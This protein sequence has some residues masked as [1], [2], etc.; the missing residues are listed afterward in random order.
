MP[1]PAPCGSW[2]SPITTD[3]IVAGTFTLRTVQ[4][5]G[6]A[7][8]W[9][10]ARPSE[11]GRNV[12]VRCAPGAATVDVTPPPWNARTRVHE[13]GDGAFCVKDGVVWFTS[14]DQRLYRLGRSG[15][16]PR[17]LTPEG[18]RY[19]D[20]CVDAA[21]GRLYAIEEDHTGEGE[22]RNRVVA[23]GADDGARVVI[24][25]GDDFYAAPRL[26]PDG[27]ELAFI[28]WNH[29]DMPW[30]ATELRTVAIGADGAF[31]APAR[32]LGGPGESVGEP[33]WAPD[34]TLYFVTDR[35]GWWNLHRRVPSDQH[36][37]AG[38]TVESVCSLEAEMSGPH[39]KFGVRSFDFLSADRAV[40]AI[41]ENGRRS[42]AV[43]DLRKGKL[44][45]VEA[46]YTEYDDVHALGEH[47]VVLLAASPWQE[48]ALVRIDLATGESDQIRRSS[49]VKVAEGY[50]APPEP[51]E[52]PTEGGLTAHG[53]YY[54]PTNADFTVPEGE[55]PPLL[56]F[57]HGGPTG[58]T[59]TALRLGIQYWTS[60]G[61]A[62]LD[63]NYGG[64]TGYGRA[65][66]ERLKGQWGVVDVQDCVAGARFLVERG[67]VDAARLAIRGG[68][69]GGYTTLCAL[70]FTDVFAA[71]ASHFGVSDLEALA[72]DT[73]KFESRYLDGLLG[74]LPEA[75]AVYEARSPIHHVERLSCPLILFQGLEDR[76]VPPNQ[77]EMMFEAL[78]KKGIPVAYVPFEGEQHGFR[79][80]ESIKRAL[81]GELYFY[82][83]VFGFEPADAIE[84]VKIENL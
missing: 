47:D 28:A 63:V 51:I 56:V 41:G 27:G 19:A 32:L 48:T 59:S 20:A 77:A 73:H 66:R 62:V 15:G 17:P 1:T 76:V 64:S 10:E 21:R 37:A 34:G 31:S 29:P 67:E 2:K 3:Q 78:K 38:G 13:Y 25:E 35:N 42:L 24:A 79:K 50:L 16:E 44:S 12:I 11:G 22:A 40:C 6:D 23:I 4:P 74:P 14:F 18:L 46:G 65:Y 68:S 58:A 60:R 5:D 8:Y 69:A 80:A 52:F 30:D 84:P 61:I 53:F 7:I 9:I 72:R 33:R 49:E 39:W 57:S 81:E 55:R 75:K 83:K 43:V 26:S 70:T 54:R 82:G 45:P 36:D 71:G